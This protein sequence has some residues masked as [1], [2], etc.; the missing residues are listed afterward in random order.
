MPP[1]VLLCDEPTSALD[2]SL[3]ATALN[4]LGRLR[5]EL[6]MSVLFVTHD[7]AAARVVADRIAVMYLGRIVEVGPAEEIAADP[8]A[9]VH[10]GAARAV[11]GEGHVGGSPGEPASPLDPPPGA[12]SIPRCPVALDDVPR[13]VPV[14]VTFGADERAVVRV[15]RTRRASSARHRAEQRLMAVAEPLR[16]AADAARRRADPPAVV[17]RRVGRGATASRSGSLGVVT[18]GR[19]LRAVDRAAQPAGSTSAMP[20]LAPGQRG[21]LLGT[22]DVGRDIFSRVLYGM[23]TTWFAALVV[24]ASGVLIGGLIGLVAGATGGWVDAVLMRITDIFLALPG[25]VLAITVVAALG[26]C[27]STR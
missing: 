6:G 20:E 15:R 24:I 27:F 16:L 19:A 23:R 4:L 12:R 13:A 5:R 8:R 22:D 14:A 1:E 2:V 11:P 7:L 17:S 18:A 3:A 10:A 25:P 21:F 9:S 26:P